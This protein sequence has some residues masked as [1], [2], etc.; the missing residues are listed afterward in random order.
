M[1][2]VAAGINYNKVHVNDVTISPLLEIFTKTTGHLREL[3]FHCFVVRSLSSQEQRE[4]VV[5]KLL[6]H[7]VATTWRERL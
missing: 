1:R 6:F 3:T 4:R 7:H 2:L 5:P